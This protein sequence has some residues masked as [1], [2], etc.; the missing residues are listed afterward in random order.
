MPLHRLVGLALAGSFSFTSMAMAQGVAADPVPATEQPAEETAPAQEN[1][2]EASEIFDRHIEAVG[3]IDTIKSFDSRLLKGRLKV[4]LAG[5]EDPRVTGILRLTA[6]APDT[7]LQEIIIPGQS[8]QT[9]TFD[10]KAGWLVENGNTAEPITDEE[11]ERFTVS[12]RFLA[13]AD[14]ENHFKS[15]KTVEQQEQG[16][17]TL[18]MVEVEHWSGR[19]EG[20]VFSEDSGLLV[21]IIGQR[22]NSSGV[23]QR[24]QR[25]YENY[26]EFDGMKIATLVRELSGNQIIEIE[27]TEIEHNV[28]PPSI[29]RPEHI[30]DADISG[31]QKP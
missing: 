31:F 3:G 4:F 23:P 14:Y 11:L 20:F 29:E 22:T 7:I 6:V 21:A 24:F 19:K 15:I 30:E 27:F 9:R 10:G 17:D 16:D 18:T 28:E 25:S 26:K 12:S 2:P 13:E 1:L 5:E 8:T